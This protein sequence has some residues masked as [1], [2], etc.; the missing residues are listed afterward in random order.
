MHNSC[1]ACGYT[2]HDNQKDKFI[3]IKNKYID[4]QNQDYIL[5]ICPLCGTVKAKKDN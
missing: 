5:H 2:E 1:V 3:K 4:E